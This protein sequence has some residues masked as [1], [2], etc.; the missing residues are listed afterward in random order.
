[1]RPALAAIAAWNRTPGNTLFFDDFTGVPDGTALNG[2][3][4]PV[5]GAWTAQGM[6]IKSEWILPD[7]SDDTGYVYFAN[8]ANNFD[9][10]LTLNL[11]SINAASGLTP[12]VGFFL[13]DASTYLTMRFASGGEVVWDGWQTLMSGGTLTSTN[14]PLIIECSSVTGHV[15]V[16]TADSIVGIWDW[17]LSNQ[18]DDWRNV[19]TGFQIS[20]PCERFAGNNFTDAACLKSVKLELDS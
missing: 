1:M 15:T 7:F 12:T 4:P 17:G 2:R 14:T 6:Q 19:I 3:K 10:K 18:P 16:R 9:F 11:L 13:K 8:P 20:L 5:G